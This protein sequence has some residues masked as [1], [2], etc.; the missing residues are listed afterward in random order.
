MLETARDANRSIGEGERG[1]PCDDRAVGRR[2]DRAFE[3]EAP[4]LLVYGAGWN[5]LP[6]IEASRR[7]GFRVVAIDRDA[8]APG[9][10]RADRFHCISLRDHEAI[11]AATRAESIRGVVARITDAEGLASA[12]TLARTRGLPTAC[13]ALVEAATSKLALS[14]H[15]RA[16]GLPMPPRLPPNEPPS[17]AA[18]PLLVRPDVTR[19]GKAGIRRVVRPEDL[20]TALAEAAA[21]SENGRIDVAR[22]IE[23]EDVSVLVEL[24]R[25]RAHRHA[26]WDEWVAL[27]AA[28][29][30]RGVGCGLP[31]RF[32]ADPDRIDGLLARLAAA[33]AASRC[34]VVVSLRIDPAGDPFLIEIH[35]GLGGDGIADRLLPAAWPEWDAFACWVR[36]EAG[37]SNELARGAA[38]PCALVRDGEGWR[39]IEAAS[40]EALHAR[41]RASIPSDWERPF[42]LRG[43][44]HSKTEAERE[45]TMK[46][47][48]EAAMKAATNDA[49]NDATKGTPK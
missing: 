21:S 34:L 4:T 2:S 7:H 15:A 47:E 25:G 46:A 40:V 42:G 16:A 43:S 32:E 22:W 1:D 49:T 17:L 19:R 11:V 33:F 5:Q 20:A 44:A 38:R 35:L 12:H 48:R 13:P 29:G 18:G 10:A 45:A 8:N 28:G 37:E 26:I 36:V 30:I 31:S 6:L 41:V 14:Q 3:G 39:L 24:D 27:D 23:G 9:A